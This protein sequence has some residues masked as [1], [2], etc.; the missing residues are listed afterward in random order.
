MPPNLPTL[1]QRKDDT[2]NGALQ[3]LCAGLRIT[4]VGRRLRSGD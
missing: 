4:D 2:N 1:A 3:G